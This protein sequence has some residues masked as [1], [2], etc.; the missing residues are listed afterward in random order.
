MDAVSG[1]GGPG[2][3]YTHGSNKEVLMSTPVL[4]T[5]LADLPVRRGKVRDIYDQGDQLL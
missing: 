4:E 3:N 1:P 2:C 5:Q